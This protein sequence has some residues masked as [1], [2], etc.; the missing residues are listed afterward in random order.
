MSDFT[1]DFEAAEDEFVSP[2]TGDSVRVELDAEVHVIFQSQETAYAAGTEVL[3]ARQALSDADKASADLI[4]KEKEINEQIETLRREFGEKLAV[5][6]NELAPLKTELFDLRRAKREA[7]YKVQAAEQKFRDA[8]N[9]IRQQEKYKQDA[10]LFDKR[11]A[12]APW[13]EWA[14]DYQ[15]EGAR[16]IASAGGKAI[17][18]DKMGLGKTLTSQIT[19]DMMDAKKILIIVP[20]DIV[21]NFLQEVGHWAPHRTAFLLGKQTKAQR[22]IIMNIMRT[23]EQFI[24]I[25]NY[26]AWRRD[27]SLLTKLGNLQFDTV[28]MD[29]AHTV[30]NISTAAFKGCKQ[31]IFTDNKCPNCGGYIQHVHDNGD[32]VWHNGTRLPRDF[33]VCIGTHLPAAATVDFLTVPVDNACGWSQ[34]SDITAG[35]ERG[36]GAYRSVQHVIPMT[37]TPILNKPQDLFALLHLMDGEHYHDEKSYLR[38]YCQQNIWT[39]KWE[40]RPGGLESLT[41]RLAGKYVARDRKTAGVVLPEQT[42]KYHNIELDEEVYVDQARV[43]R[44]LSKHAMLM[45]SS[46]VKLPIIAMIALIT[47]KR[48]ANVWPGGIE[49]TD[50]Q[51]GAVFAIG[52]EVNESVKLDRIIM[53][54][55]RTESG[56][57]EGMIPDFT[58]GGDK[59]NG[60]RVVIFSQF[61]QP[62]KELER[63]L[64]HAGISVV[65]FDG[66]TPE[67]I[68]YQ[69]KRDFDRKHCS[70]TD[71]KWQVVLANY[72]TGGVGLNFTAATQMII[73]DEEWNVGKNEQAY[74]RVDRLGQTEETT[75]HILRLSN[76]IDTWMAELIEQK[77]NMVEGFETNAEMANELLRKMQNGEMM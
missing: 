77:R 47:R 16:L 1:F 39:D 72:R 15:I 50:P 36:Y 7:E 68:R 49:I 71:Y 42:I 57:W 70:E 56:D 11:C 74:A 18:A 21:S 55:E 27:K 64:N 48:Q 29:E 40:F 51:S 14:K 6:Q 38:A 9:F 43:I 69:V 62:L 45:L 61:K 76:T 65:R 19:L 53:E 30:K 26:S 28:I 22:D 12:A 54:P 66:D 20:D 35:I 33:Y 73:L 4:A 60:E 23:L 25:I 13:R 3:N 37:G 58:G 41:K 31:I 2:V 24:A 75:V 59:I 44:Q 46:G 63:R 67:D 8:L 32:I 5:L 17:L 10:E 52:D 34:R